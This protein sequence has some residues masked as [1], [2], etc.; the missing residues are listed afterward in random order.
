MGRELGPRA[1]LYLLAYPSP[2]PP[3]M[4]HR[5]PGCWKQEKGQRPG[6]PTVL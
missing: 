5:T 6:W 3:W 1:G 2:L 4:G